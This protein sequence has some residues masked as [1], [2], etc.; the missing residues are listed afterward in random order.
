METQFRPVPASN[1]RLGP[2]NG[3]KVKGSGPFNYSGAAGR[4]ASGLEPLKSPDVGQLLPTI[5]WLAECEVSVG[6]ALKS[7]F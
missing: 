6:G 5:W 2:P 4:Q 3:S 7:T 1:R